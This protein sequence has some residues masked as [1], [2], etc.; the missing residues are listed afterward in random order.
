MTPT[1]FEQ[2]AVLFSEGEP[3]NR[4][5]IIANGEVEAPFYGLSFWLEK[6]DVIGLCDLATG[7]HSHTYSALSKTTVFSYPYEDY[8]TLE[9]LIRGNADTAYF[10]LS[11]MCRQISE[12]LH[13]RAKLKQEVER[14]YALVSE[15]YPDYARLCKTYAYTPK[16]LTGLSDVA[17]F[18][19]PGLIDDWLQDYY[20]EIK[21][22]EPNAHKK[23]FYKKPG[24]SMGFLRRCAE[25]VISVRQACKL[26]L[27]YIEEISA[28]F[29][30]ADGF[31]LLALVTDLHLYSINIKGADEA[32]TELISPLL[33]LMSNMTCIDPER[34]ETRVN[35]Y[36]DSLEEKRGASEMTDAPAASGINQKLLDS[37]DTILTYSDCDEETGNNFRRN[38]Q[39]YTAFSASDRTDDVAS[40]VRREL[41]GLFYKIYKD[42]LIKSLNDPAPSTIIKMFLDFGYVDAEL[43][44]FENADYL[45][46]IADSL[47][48]DPDCHIYTI[49][50]WLG[51]I[52][53]GSVEPSLSEFEMD[54]PAYIRE[55][56][57]T[58]KLDDKEV[59]RLL[60]DREEK[61]RFE[62]EN[63]FPVLNRVTFGK[64][65]RF[66]P[67]FADHNVQRKL[68]SLL[69]A[70]EK[71]REYLDEI[72]SIDFSAYYR[73]TA[74]TDAQHGIKDE[75]I[76]VE[77]L[78]NIV[79][80][81]NVG[82][83]ASMWQ[84]IEGRLRTTPARMFMP[85]FLDGDLKAMLIRLTG[86]FRWEIC[87]RIQGARWNDVT[88]PSL[89]SL[90]SD[91]LQFY[92]NN[93]NLSMETM[94]AIRNEL[95][96]ARNNFKTV[97]VSNYAIWLL[98]ES[99]GA[100]RLNKTAQTIFVSFC[101]F[102]AKIREQLINNPRYSELLNRYN[103]KQQQRIKRLSNLKQQVS[104]R[105]K[106]VPQEILDEIEFAK[107]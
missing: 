100:A 40:G 72:R 41:T 24:I 97:F 6:T 75:T 79:L 91:Y 55:L 90:F 80:M 61:L 48:G 49:S 52:Y 2:G 102:P 69:V 13:Y 43:A 1:E 105:G 23:F 20:M 34:Y 25:D 27:E 37:M 31:D 8:G 14:T 104:Q 15:L 71:V 101:P 83:R 85:V 38:I 46:S 21:E 96:S 53:H 106:G 86:E 9:A 33:A 17:P 66:C 94:L 74:F 59:K 82:M 76:N 39:E 68:D 60:E 4:L 92:M 87:K 50:E 56:K 28:L 32:I 57:T 67:V 12:F 89:T 3:L 70:P 84:D 42:V 51:A 93:R 107:R 88:D 78:P 30:N 7:I 22:T 29:L 98:N 64:P 16:K 63:A 35:A 54:Y 99:K 5:Y 58:Q 11:S 45:Y 73:E 26:Y 19:E 44:G 62:L 18:S 103:N 47:K 95:S 65:T 77:V 81:P 10:M 36:M